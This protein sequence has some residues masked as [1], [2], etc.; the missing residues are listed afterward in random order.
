MQ[1]TLLP[2][3]DCNL[4][5]TAKTDGRLCSTTAPLLTRVCRVENMLRDIFYRWY[6]EAS[7]NQSTCIMAPSPRSPVDDPKKPEPWLRQ[8]WIEKDK[9]YRRLLP[10]WSTTGR[11]SVVKTK[12]DK[13]VRGVGH[14][15]AGEAKYWYEFGHSANQ[16]S[17]S[18]QIYGALPNEE[19]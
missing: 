8:R 3:L 4:F 1:H 17:S 6:F 15:E 18:A 13:T 10:Y 2:Q 12:R 9:F 11:R 7:P 16:P 19:I 5:A 14:I